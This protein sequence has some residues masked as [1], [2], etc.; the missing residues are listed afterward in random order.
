MTPFFSILSVQTNSFSHETVAVGLLVVADKIYFNFSNSKLKFLKNL[1]NGKGMHFLAEKN[2]N[3]IA[4]SVNKKNSTKQTQAVKGIYSVEYFKYLNQYATGALVF[5][6]PIALNISFN[7]K[8]YSQYYQQMIGEPLSIKD[9][10]PKISFKSKIKTLL[11]KEGLDAKA[12][13]NYTLKADKLSGVLKN[14][15][16]SLITVNGDISCLQA[17]DMSINQDSIIHHIYETQII[18]DGLNNFAKS[19]NKQVD[20]IKLAIEIP[21]NKKQK[22]FFDK[23]YLEKKDFFDFY[24]YEQVKEFA[25]KIS[26]SDQFSKFSELI[27]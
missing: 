13:I 14:T 3:K 21:E 12:D 25:S 2:L 23:I 10:K 7:E 24:E 16:V 17:I 15:K 11:E 27:E 22:Q 6:E 19:H 8:V 18:F 20:K 9:Q 26:N 4:K 5:S 1:N